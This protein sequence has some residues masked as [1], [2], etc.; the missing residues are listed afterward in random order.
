MTEV[1]DKPDKVEELPTGG[2]SDGTG[3]IT[4]KEV[5]ELGDRYIPFTTVWEA[6]AMRLYYVVQNKVAILRGGVAF[7]YE[8]TVK[9]GIFTIKGI[10]T[11]VRGKDGW[12]DDFY[13]RR[14]AFSGICEVRCRRIELR[15]PAL[16]DYCRERVTSACRSGNFECPIKIP[17]GVSSE[18]VRMMV[19]YLGVVRETDKEIVFDVRGRYA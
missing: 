14:A 7:V 2:A 5:T 15:H 17:A 13:S 6:G 12:K 18:D 1:K 4:V 9:N 19:Y 3:P 16:S 10:G 11:P 8:Y